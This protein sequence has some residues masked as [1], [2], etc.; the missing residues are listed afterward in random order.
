MQLPETDNL[1]VPES[2]QCDLYSMMHPEKRTI[3]AAALLFSAA[4]FTVFAGYTSAEQD[5]DSLQRVTSL[6]TAEKHSR[7]GMVSTGS[8]EATAAA[9]RILEQGG[10]AIDAAVTAAL[11][12]GVSDPADSG[13]GGSA[14]VVAHLAD[15]RSFAIDG[16]SITPGQFNKSVIRRIEKRNLQR[17]IELAAVPGQLRAI[18]LLAAEYG[19]KSL[20]ELIQPAIRVAD[21]GYY[22]TPFQHFTAT[23]YRKQLLASEHCR[24]LVLKNGIDLHPLN[25]PVRRPILLQTMR[26]LAEH[27]VDDFYVGSIAKAIA[28]DMQQRGGFITASD[29]KRVKAS[30]VRPLRVKYRSAEIL[31]FPPPGMGAA[32]A[33]ALKMLET[34]S[35]DLLRQHSVERMHVLSS[36]FKIM[37]D[38]HPIYFSQHAS[39]P[40]GKRLEEF[41][42]THARN[43]ARSITVDG[44]A[45]T[46]AART[47]RQKSDGDTNTTQVSVIDRWGNAVS[48]TQSIGRYYGGKVATATL[49]FPYN[50]HLENLPPLRSRSRIPSSIAP[51]IVLQGNKPILVLGSAGSARIPSAIATVISNVIDGGLPLGQAIVAPRVLW[52][53]GS[54]HTGP[55][56]EVMPPITSAD[57]SSFRAFGHSK[58]FVVQPPTTLAVVQRMG[59]V[60]AVARDSKTGE[61]TGAGDPRRH[62]GAKG[63][64]R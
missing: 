54:E 50:S 47:T 33:Q 57:L 63:A 60:N 38:D 8:Q 49:G 6:R 7:Y 31:T 16:S 1:V 48:L 26:R 32:V 20:Q 4:L 19:T 9:V 46:P 34:F 62:G 28:T 52:E 41:I 39:A 3:R 25:T 23:K 5:P 44:A 18:A 45:E 37:L 30:E 61:L 58:V 59:G 17:G 56:V 53:I 21:D 12:L 42:A 10:N 14:L 11:V 15:G 35:P 29:L 36:V 22:P 40:R 13:F 64:K 55:M 2:R 51:T 24:F 43:R 27:G